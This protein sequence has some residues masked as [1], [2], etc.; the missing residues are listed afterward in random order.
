LIEGF[1]LSCKVENKSTATIS[2]YKSICW[3]IC[4][5]VRIMLSYNYKH[6]RKSGGNYGRI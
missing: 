5:G 1:L 3:E 6:N 4:A 2:F